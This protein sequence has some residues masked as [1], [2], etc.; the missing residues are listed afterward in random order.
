MGLLRTSFEQRRAIPFQLRGVTLDS[1]VAAFQLRPF[2][3]AGGKPTRRRVVM[4]IRGR[5]MDPCG[6]EKPLD[7]ISVQHDRA[8]RAAL[9]R[10]AAR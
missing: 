5:V 4:T 7:E 3:I 6:G 1:S 9:P 8:Y 2:L 10:R